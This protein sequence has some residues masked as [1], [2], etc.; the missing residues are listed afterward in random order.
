MATYFTDFSTQ[1]AGVAPTGWTE[2]WDTAGSW[3]VAANAGFGGAKNGLQYVPGTAAPHGLSWDILDADTGR[4]DIE[5]VYRWKSS[6]G[7]VSAAND[8]RVFARAT[9]A[10]AAEA[11]G[12]AVGPVNTVLRT[13]TYIAGVKT[14]TNATGGAVTADVWYWSRVRINGSTIQQKMWADGTTEPT[15]WAQSI[16]NTQVTGVGWAGVFLGVLA[17]TRMTYD[18]LGVGTAGA[19]A[20]TA[21]AATVTVSAGNDQSVAP[22]S[23][24]TL[25]GTAST[26]SGTISARAWSQLAGPTVTLSGAST[27]TATFTPTVADEYTFRFTATDSNGGSASDDVTVFV[28]SAGEARPT[29]TVTPGAW[30][31]VGASTLHAALADESAATYAESVDNPSGASFT[32]DLAPSTTGAKTV[33]YTLIASAAPGGSVLV[34]Y[35]SAGVVV[36]S[37]NE[38]VSTTTVTQSRVLTATQNANV[39]DPLNHQLRFTASV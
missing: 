20:P 10:T 37:W 16:T 28:T 35:L 7:G 36:A 27:A 17:A 23:P 8:V 11:N 3:T 39:T 34:E 12:Y 19:T 24:V 18:C 30:T 2:R 15:T 25:T 33:N 9:G 5:F 38:T 32:V 26:T 21:G 4:A 13:A 29:A 6:V 31:A 1:T 14:D 22:S